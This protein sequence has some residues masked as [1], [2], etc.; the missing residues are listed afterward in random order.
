[1][2]LKKY[3]HLYPKIIR[4]FLKLFF[5]GKIVPKRQ[6]ELHSTYFGKRTPDDGKVSWDWQRERIYNWV[7]AL[8]PPYYPGAFC[9]IK[10]AKVFIHKISLSDFGFSYNTKNGSVLF[11]GT[12][13]FTVK[14][15]N[16]CIEI[17]DYVHDVDTSIAPGDILA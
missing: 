3:L 10:N 7:R 13:N 4:E 2:I 5:E 6:N 11:V 9:F 15:P 17:T 14:T 16:G 12:N 1:M 8:A